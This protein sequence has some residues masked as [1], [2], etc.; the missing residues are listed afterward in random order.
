MVTIL[1]FD[2][3]TNKLADFCSVQIYCPPGE[4]SYEIIKYDTAHG[5]CHV[6]RYYKNL[7]ALQEDIDSAD[8]SKHTFYKLK[9]DVEA[10]WQKYKEWYCINGSNKQNI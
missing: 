6:H 5:K 7:K 10:N 1:E 2:L 3:K 9:K 8:I 4:K